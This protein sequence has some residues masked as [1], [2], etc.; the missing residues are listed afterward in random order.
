MSHLEPNMPDEFGEKARR[1]DD[2]TKAVSE[3]KRQGLKIPAKMKE[4]LDK[5]NQ[6]WSKTRIFRKL[7]N[8]PGSLKVTV[9]TPDGITVVSCKVECTV[10]A[11]FHPETE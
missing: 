4:E 3:M 1:L 9:P 10:R 11:T 7:I 8:K 6:I 2:L 5:L